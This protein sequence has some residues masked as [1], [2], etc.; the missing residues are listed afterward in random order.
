MVRKTSPTW[1]LAYLLILSAVLA[2][3]FQTP[4]I[5]ADD[6]SRLS[7]S[8]MSLGGRYIWDEK[9]K[10][11]YFSEK[12]RLEQII[13]SSGRERSLVILLDCMD[14]D[15]PTQTLLGDKHVALGML[16]YQAL[17]Q[18]IYYEPNDASGDIDVKWPGYVTADATIEQL[19]EAKKA[20]KT[21]VVAKRHIFL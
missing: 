5:K 19:R 10:R 17:T 7:A 6:T 9:G 14:D 3:C 13:E 1:R 4:D 8:L 18:T 16:C 20:W 21:V 15:T 11:F 2:G 12:N